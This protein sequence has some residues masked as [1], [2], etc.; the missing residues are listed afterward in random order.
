MFDAVQKN[1][2]LLQV[3]LAI[4][5]IPFA[6]F[7][8]ESYTRSMRGADDVASVDGMAISQK[9]FSD[10]LRQQQDRLRAVLG[11]GFDASALD[12]PETRQGLLDSLVSERLVSGAALKGNLAVSDDSLRE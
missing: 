10:S 6:F 7:G 12:T 5:I 9:E 2:R 8:L 3:V 1:K 4:I 11:K